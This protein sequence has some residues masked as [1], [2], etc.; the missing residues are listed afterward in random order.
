MPTRVGMTGI[1][2]EESVSTRTGST[3]ALPKSVD[4]ISL[5]AIFRYKPLR[6]A[7]KIGTSTSACTIHRQGRLIIVLTISDFAHRHRKTVRISISN[8]HL[9][10]WLM[11][12][13]AISDQ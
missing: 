7:H 2:G 10:S 3:E 4:P 6:R 11:E 12:I 13:N 5:F 8:R 1:A 9:P